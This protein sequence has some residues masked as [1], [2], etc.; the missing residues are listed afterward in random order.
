MNNK[1]SIPLV[2]LTIHYNFSDAMLESQGNRSTEEETCKEIM[3]W[4]RGAPD[5]GHG[6][7]RRR[8]KAREREQQEEHQ[9][10]DIY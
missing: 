10:D 8:E 7:A 9:N 6:R 5:R 1:Y 3:L 2:Y 4:L